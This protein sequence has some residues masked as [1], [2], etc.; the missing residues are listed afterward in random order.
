MR[1]LIIALAILVVAAPAIAGPKEEAFA[2]IE[3]FKKAYDASD[4]PEI[5][6]TFA[7]DAVFLGTT[8]QKPTSETEAILK[9]FQASAA[10]NLPKKIV[11]ENYEALQ[12]SE[13]AI[14]F[15]GQDV[16]FQT[17]D[18]KTVETPARFTLL[19]TNGVQ[20]WRISHFHSSRRPDAQ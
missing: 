2:V 8:M 11:I 12:I 6:K 17:R 19:I 1:Y 10:A 4:P 13:S 20:G 3:Q 14:L 7:P 18:G 5:V 15:S 16:F 9:Y